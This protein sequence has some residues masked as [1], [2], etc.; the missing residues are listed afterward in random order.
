MTPSPEARLCA[1]KKRCLEYASGFTT[2]NLSVKKSRALCSVSVG[3]CTSPKVTC[4]QN[5]CLA[6]AS[7]LLQALAEYSASNTQGSDEVGIAANPWRNE[8]GVA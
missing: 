6:S 2:D 1:T 5:G 7:V 4:R 8:Y 3:H